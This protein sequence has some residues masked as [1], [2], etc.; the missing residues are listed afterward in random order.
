MRK[1]YTKVNR[2][3]WVHDR[4]ELGMGKL[5]SKSPRTEEVDL[6]PME[7]VRELDVSPMYGA[8]VHGP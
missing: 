1:A 5:R 8:F 4:D 7:R 6:A 2:L 3:A